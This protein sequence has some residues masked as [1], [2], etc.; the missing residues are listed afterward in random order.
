MMIPYYQSENVTLYNADCLDAVP[1]L[2]AQSIDTILTDVPYGTTA[3]SWD[4][5]IPFPDMWKIVKHVLKRKGAFVTTASQPFT[6][7]LVCSNLEWFK[8]EWIWRKNYGSNFM[9]LEHRPFLE[10]ENI[11]VFS[12]NT[13]VYNPQKIK[14]AQSS[15]KRDKPGVLRISKPVTN[16]K[17]GILGDEFERTEQPRIGLYRSPSSV[18]EFDNFIRQG[19]YGRELH[20]TKKPE[21][22]YR[23]LALTYTN[24]GDTV[25]DFC[26]GSGTTGVA[27]I[28]TGRKFIGVEISE[29]YCKIAVKRIRDA[30]QQMR[31]F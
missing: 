6:S 19:R 1:Q 8:Y 29:D 3:C 22:L 4:V 30:E 16:K 10:H 26:F 24:P 13:C 25:L 28:Q 20:P 5:I 18:L 17:V 31:L 12:Q 21:A 7:K 15:L 14:K 11:L 9:T 27:C 2:E 23:Y